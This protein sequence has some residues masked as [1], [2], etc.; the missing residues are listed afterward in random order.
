MSRK[1]DPVLVGSFVIGAILLAVGGI[2]VIGG[3]RLNQ[4]SYRCVLYFSGSLRGLDVGAPVTYRGVNIGRVAAINITFD[5]RKMQYRIPVYVD[6]TGKGSRISSRYREWGFTSAD[7][8]FKS[9]IRRGLQAR[10]KMESL[11]T[12]KLYIEFAFAPE[13]APARVIRQDGYLEI[14]TVPSDLEQLTQAMEELP[15][16]ELATTALSALEG[17][18]RLV[19]SPDLEQGLASFNTTMRHVD[20]LV[21]D[22]DRRL[23]TLQ[24]ELSRL[25]A[26]ISDLAATANALLARTGKDLT[27]AVRDLRQTLAS[28]NRAA[29]TLDQTLASLNTVMATNRELPYELRQSLVEVRRAARAMRDLARYLRR[30][31]NALLTGPGEDRP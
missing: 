23:D 26:D 1:A 24:P 25:L 2:M 21:T 9:L 6:I 3:L 12:G 28:I 15:L 16:K 30:H 10:L 7:D 17:I 22:T 11:V 20:S 27:P 18:D 8:F 31:P 5:R 29:G 14:P 4:E 13:T 19:N